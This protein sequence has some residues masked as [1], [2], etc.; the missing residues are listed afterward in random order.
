MHRLNFYFDAILREALARTRRV[1]ELQKVLQASVPAGLASVLEVRYLDSGTLFVAAANGAA[2][3]KLKQM[4]PS[5][6]EAYRERGCELVEIR[7]SVNV[8]R[9]A[10]PPVTRS[11]PELGPEARAQLAKLERELAESPLKKT[12][13]AML[14]RQKTTWE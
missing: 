2:A 1:R 12:L 5:L 6:I 11:K 9:A 13:Q 7:V 3:A 8:R 10:A 4:L 14:R